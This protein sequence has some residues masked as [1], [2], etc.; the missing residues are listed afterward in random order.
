M[1]YLFC[2]VSGAALGAFGALFWLQRDYKKRIDEINSRG[3]YGENTD[4][5]GNSGSENAENQDKNGPSDGKNKAKKKEKSDE[6][7][8]DPALKQAEIEKKKWSEEQKKSA[9]R[10][11]KR[12]GYVNYSDCS[13]SDRADFRDEN[14]Y[15]P[16]QSDVKES[17]NEDS[18][19][20]NKDDSGDFEDEN[21][22]EMSEN[23]ENKAIRGDNIRTITHEDYLWIGPEW[24]K[25]EIKYY[26]DN[27]VFCDEDDVCVPFLVQCVT[28]DLQKWHAKIAELQP[29]FV[30]ILNEKMGSAY[31]ISVIYDA[32]VED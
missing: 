18:D 5:E 14:G 2:F 30:W 23:A 4:P 16:G 20:E 15:S 8:E 24:Q 27:D 28:S 13:A 10:L 29:D 7:D 11:S 17:E 22:F 6:N 26:F 25:S 12:H 1:K 32:Y 19:D 3:N 31:E 9:E 21:D